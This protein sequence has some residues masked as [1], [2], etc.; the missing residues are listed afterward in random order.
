ML[1]FLSKV[2][3]CMKKERHI[4]SAMKIKHQNVFVGIMIVFGSCSILMQLISRF[5]L[6]NK[7]YVF[8]ILPNLNRNLS[9]QQG[10]SYFTKRR[11][12][13]EYLSQLSEMSLAG[14]ITV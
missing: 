13:K 8:F 6:M 4:S 2:G 14:K 9:R 11:C 12:D 3:F 7:L 1:G 5:R 10:N